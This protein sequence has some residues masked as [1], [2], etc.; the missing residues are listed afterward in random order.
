M[1]IFDQLIK[2][3]SARFLHYKLLYIVISKNFVA[4]YFEDM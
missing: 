2:V 4:R 3:M 1:F